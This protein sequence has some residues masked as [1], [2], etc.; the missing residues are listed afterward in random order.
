LFGE[1]RGGLRILTL[2][3]N[4]KIKG[5]LGLLFVLGIDESV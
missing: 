5:L 2:E 3:R 4:C 1:R